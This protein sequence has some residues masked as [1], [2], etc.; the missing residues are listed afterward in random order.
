[1]IGTVEFNAACLYRYS[2]VDVH[3]LVENL[4]GDEDLAGRGLRAY[5]MATITT[6]PSGKQNSMAAHNPPSLVFIVRRDCGQWN[7]AN[8]FADPVRPR[9]GH[10]LVEGSI[11]R[12]FKYYD[13]LINAYPP[14]Q[15]PQQAGCV[16]LGTEGVETPAAVTPYPTIDGL[17]EAVGGV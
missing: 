13:D 15:A 11:N 10:P 9:A 2:C 1:M 12:L 17:V 16:L 4:D 8:A 7:L 6:L 3:Q 14:S 5:L